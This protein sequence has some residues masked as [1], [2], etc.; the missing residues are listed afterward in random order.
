MFT[1]GVHT[2]DLK[3]SLPAI[4][5]CL[6]SPPPP[7]WTRQSLC[8][9]AFQPLWQMVDV[10][11]DTPDTDLLALIFV[12]LLLRQVLYTTDNLFPFQVSA[13]CLGAQRV[14]YNPNTFFSLTLHLQEKPQRQRWTPNSPRPIF[15]LPCHSVLS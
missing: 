2:T 12:R 11:Y 10:T 9:L 14:T 3:A 6:L 8:T 4:Q 7:N 15:S 5:S 13:V 1:E